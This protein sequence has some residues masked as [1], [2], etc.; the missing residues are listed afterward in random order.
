MDLFAGT[1]IRVVLHNR[2]YVSILSVGPSL[3]VCYVIVAC[4]I[5]KVPLW[6]SPQ[7]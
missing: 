1:G 7:S 3:L 5:I 6:S 2:L 4:K